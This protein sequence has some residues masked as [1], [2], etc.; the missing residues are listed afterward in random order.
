M[1][2]RRSKIPAEKIPGLHHYLSR[3]I[4]AKSKEG[5]TYARMAELIGVKE[6]TVTRWRDFVTMPS[7]E[8]ANRAIEVL[9]GS[10]MEAILESEE[11]EVRAIFQAIKADKELKKALFKL[12]SH[13]KGKDKIKADCAFF[14]ESPSE[15][16]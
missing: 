3:L 15:E 4:L 12:L 8:N 13:K 2:M 1:A 14:F 6:S 11:D 9:G 5:M 10:L 7:S 16:N